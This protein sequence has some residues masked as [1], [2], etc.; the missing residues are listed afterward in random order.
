VTEFRAIPG[1]PGYKAEVTPCTH[2]PKFVSL[3]FLAGNPIGDPA[4]SR[5]LHQ[6]FPKPPKALQFKTIHAQSRLI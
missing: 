2:K 1:W 5:G 4:V 3:H 6:R